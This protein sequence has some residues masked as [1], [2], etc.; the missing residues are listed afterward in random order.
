MTIQTAFF[1][2]FPNKTLT[3]SQ[4]VLRQKNP[5]QLFQVLNVAYDLCDFFFPVTSFIESFALLQCVE[6]ANRDHLSAKTAFVC[7]KGWSLCTGFTV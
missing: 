3:A 5:L 1:V 4:E 7:T 2:K 6:P